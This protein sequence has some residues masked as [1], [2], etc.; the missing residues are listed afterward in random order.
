MQASSK[1]YSI[2]NSSIGDEEFS[3][4]NE[5]ISSFAYRK[6]IKRLASKAKA[7]QHSAKPDERHILDKPLM[8][9][10][11]VSQSQQISERQA[12]DDSLS[13]NSINPSAN[14]EDT[15]GDVSKLVEQ[16]VRDNTYRQA[17]PFR[18][19]PREPLRVLVEPSRRFHQGRS[20]TAAAVNG[21]D[22]YDVPPMPVLSELH[23]SDIRQ[24]SLSSEQTE[25]SSPPGKEGQRAGSV[26]Q[27]NFQSVTQRSPHAVSPSPRKPVG[28]SGMLDTNDSNVSSYTPVGVRNGSRRDPARKHLRS[29]LVEFY[30]TDSQVHTKVEVFTDKNTYNKEKA[31]R[32]TERLHDLRRDSFA[33]EF[34]SPSLTAVALKQPERE[35]SFYIHNEEP[36]MPELGYRRRRVNDNRQDS[37]HDAPLLFRSTP[38]KERL[39]AHKAMEKLAGK[40]RDV[41]AEK[42]QRSSKTRSRS[43]SN[44]SLTGDVKPRLLETVENAISHSIKPELETL[45]QKQEMQQSRQKF[46][47][48]NRGSV[49][50]GRSV[51]GTDLSRK[52]FK[53]GISDMSEKSKMFLDRDEHNADILLS[54]DLI[55]DRKDDRYFDSPSERRLERDM[56]EE[57]VVRDGEKHSR[58]RSKE[59]RSRDATAEAIAGGMLTAAALHYHDLEYKSSF[60]R[61]KQRR[62]RRRR[63]PSLDHGGIRD[64]EAR[65]GEEAFE[66]NHR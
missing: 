10:F 12:D 23:S 27:Q 14:K 16:R 42:H 22:N 47:R 34:S 44:N 6:A 18:K 43:V 3:F 13:W 15:N 57:T 21:F 17:R 62:R 56:S 1:D 53:K 4:D 37:K 7:T 41:G 30:H 24:D 63:Y 46:D 31:S 2:F 8:P 5:I 9:T 54:G 55:K 40:P 66:E 45:E 36:R 39:L 29:L 38:S 48:D 64:C 20:T 65:V 52:L 35:N 50:S 33:K 58:K 49:D 26:V 11:T 25:T 32:Q 60:D 28:V 51:S 59:H 19:F 61:K